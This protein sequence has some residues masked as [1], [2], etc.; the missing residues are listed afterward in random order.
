MCFPSVQHQTSN[1]DGLIHLNPPIGNLHQFHMWCET[2]FEY[3]NFKILGA[4][5][6]SAFVREVFVHID[7]IECYVTDPA[8][9]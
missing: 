4:R 6:T 2:Y 9:L 1:G 5:F 8:K 3:P 7:T